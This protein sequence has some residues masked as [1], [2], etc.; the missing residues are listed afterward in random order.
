MKEKGETNMTRAKKIFLVAILSVIIIAAGLYVWNP[1]ARS[2][3][4]LADMTDEFSGFE[5]CFCD[6]SAGNGSY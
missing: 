5:K 3:E 2:I 4:T 6:R 1:A